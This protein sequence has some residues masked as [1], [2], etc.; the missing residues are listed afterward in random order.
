MNIKMKHC[1][2]MALTALPSLLMAQANGKLNSTVAVA[3]NWV[4]NKAEK[5]TV[6]VSIENS[7]DK[8]ATANVAL[9][10]KTDKGEPYTEVKATANLAAGTKKD[11]AL[12]FRQ[13]PPAGFYACTLTVNDD[14]I[15]TFNIGIEPTEVVWLSTTICPLWLRSRLPS[16]LS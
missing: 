6:N 2:L 9:W 4:W 11:V 10:V 15:R 14:T 1:L 13:T 12:D 7:G 16:I 5:P 3:H 8:A